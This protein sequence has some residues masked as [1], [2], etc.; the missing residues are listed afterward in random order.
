VAAAREELL[1]RE[2]DGLLP[3][4]H[5]RDVTL[6]L[7]S[8]A[9]LARLRAYQ[10]RMGWHLPW[11]SSA[12]TDFSVD[13]VVYQMYAA[14]GRGVEFLMGYYPIP[15]RVPKGRDEGDAPQTWI[16]RHDGYA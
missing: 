12:R 15:D 13:F 14:T 11:V 10:R 9:P 5:A 4:R 3:H 16:H 8:Q 2:K 7:V 1:N 6:M